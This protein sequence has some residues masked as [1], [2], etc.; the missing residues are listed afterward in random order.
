MP[1][2]DDH[3]GPQESEPSKGVVATRRASRQQSSGANKG[4]RH[5]SVHRCVSADTHELYEVAGSTIVVTLLILSPPIVLVGVILLTTGAIISKIFVLIAGLVTIL[6]GVLVAAI[7]AFV[8]VRMRGGGGKGARTQNGCN[9]SNAQGSSVRSR[10]GGPRGGSGL[11]NY[12][13]VTM[14]LERSTNSADGSFRVEITEQPSSMVTFFSTADSD[15]QPLSTVKLKSSESSGS[16][17][18][19]APS[20]Q[21]VEDKRNSFSSENG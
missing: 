11:G 5:S 7:T 3:P 6:S 10:C 17:N 8:F 9:I 18:S 16:V 14:D 13:R 12:Y 1:T 20:T 19:A 15:I 4:E 2:N 21:G